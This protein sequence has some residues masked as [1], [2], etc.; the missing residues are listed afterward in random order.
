MIARVAGA[1]LRLAARLLFALS[2]GASLQAQA[3][4]CVAE[5]GGVID[6]FVTPTPPSQIQID[7]NCTVRNF[8]ASNPLTTNFSFLTQPGQTD[9]R[10]L[11]IF[12]NVVHTGNM[13]CDAVHEHK[14]WFTNSSIST[15]SPNC[16]NLL[17]PVEK[18]DKDSP[19][20]SA[21]IGV[22]FTYRL[23][24]PVL[25]D[26][27]TGNVIDF[28]GSPN[29]LHGII[30]TDDLNETGV[31]LTYLS[32]TAYWESSGAPVPHIFDNDAG[33]LTFDFTGQIVP[34]ETQFVIDITVVL[35][36]VPANAIGTSFVNT[37]KWQF[38]RLIDDV[39]YQ[40]LP[41]EWGISQ[42]MTIVAPDLTLTKSGPATMN[43]AP[44]GQ[45]VLD[46]HNVGAGDAWNVTIRDRLPDGPNGGMCDA[47][48][49]IVS[50]TIGGNPIAQ[51]SGYSLNYSGAPGCE[52]TLT[53]LD[54]AGPIGPDQH[55]LVTYRARLDADTDNGVTLTNVAGAV[56]WFNGNSTN[57]D[58]VGFNRPLTTG[59]VGTLDHQDAHTVTVALAG[60]LF[61][62]TVANLRSGDNP[63]AVAAP[64]DTLRYTLRVQTTNAS[65]DGFSIHD[66][67]DALNTPAAFAPGTLTL[68]GS[69]PPGAVNNSNAAGGAKGTGVIDISNLNLPANSQLIVQFDITV[70]ATATAGSIVANQAQI[71]TGSTPVML[72]D[73]PNVNG[74]ADPF[75]AGDEDPTRVTIVVPTLQLTKT[76]V[77][78]ST[79]SPSDVVRYRLQLTN[80]SNVPFSG[81]SLIDE[82][83]QLNSSA[84]FVPGTLALASALPG[85]ATNNSNASGGSRGTGLLDI[86]N[87]SIGAQGSPNDILTIEFTAQLVPVIDNGTVVLNQGRLMAG[88]TALL[89]SD[90]PAIAGTQDP[91]PIVI[92]S[93]PVFR[94][95]KVS[96]DM[97]G[98]ANVLLPGDTLR[99]TITVKNVGNANATDAVLRDQIPANTTYVAGSTRLNGTSVADVGGL[100][101][102]VSGLSI[103][104]PENPTPGAMRA[105]SSATTSN[106][107]TIMFDVTIDADT[108][109]GTIISNQAFISAPSNAVI[110]TPSDDPTTPIVSDPT[111]DIV[112]Y[113]PLIYAEK[114]A[115]L[116]VDGGTPGVID[117]NDV[118]RYTIT[119]YN[120]GTAAAT[121][122]ALRDQ[123]PANTTY[124]ADSTTL[125]GLPVARP[126]G[127][128][129]PLIAGLPISS[130]DLTPPVPAAGQGTLSV[131]ATATI[132]FDLRVNAGV[133]A[134]TLISNQATVYSDQLPQQL[135][136]GDGNPATGPEP[137]VV[138]VGSGQQLSITKQVAVVGGGAALAGSTL[139]YIVRVTNIATVPAYYIVVTDD[140][141][142]ATP[143]YLTYVD[144]S[145]TL[146]G[147]AAGISVAGSVITADYY[148]TY[149]PLQPGASAVLRFRATIIPNA[150]IGTRV[151]N[152]ADVTWNNPPQTARASVS[153]DVGGVVGVGILSGHVWHDA[154]FNQTL[155]TNERLFEDWRVDL[156]RNDRVVHTVRTDANGAY[157]ISGIAPNY[158][159]ADRYE[160]RFTAPNAS[161]STA[162]LGRAYSM[163]TNDLQRIADIIVQPGSNLPNMDLPLAPNGVVYNTIA[164]TPI[165]GATLTMRNGAGAALPSSCFYD[166]AQQ[167]Q[168]TLDYGYYRFDL[169]FADP[170]CPSG[171]DYFIDVT[172]PATGYIA[173]PSQIIPPASNALAAALSVPTCPGSADDAIAATAQ[174]CEVQP[175]EFAPQPAVRAR[176]IGTR[177]YLHMLFDDSLVPG[178][179][180]I[181]NNH[182]P[183]DPDM[184]GLLSLTKTTPLLNVTRGQL[185]PYTITYR[186]VT[187]VPLFDVRL[188]DRL[189]PGFSYV[190]GSARIDD[191]PAE[192]TL[193]GR[194]LLWSDL[195]VDGSAHHTLKLLLAVGAGVGEGEF[196]NR[197][198]SIHQ[199]TTRPLS[200]EATATV[201]VVPDATFD[202]T[203]VTGK[204]FD[205]VNRNGYQ[206]AGERG[207]SG[208]RVVSARGLTAITDGYGRFHITCAVTPREDRGSNFVLKLDDRTLPSGYRASTQPVRVERATRG[209]ALRFNF[210]ASIHRVVGLDLTDAVFEPGTTQM[211]DHWKPR[212][213]LLIEQLRKGPAVLRLSYLAD[214]ENEALVQRRLAA[215]KEEIMHRW[216]ALNCCYALT[217]EPEVF[218]RLGAPPQQTGMR[219]PHPTTEGR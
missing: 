30:V 122:V 205:D 55:L 204:V 203:D 169:S 145:A 89:L 91:T 8:P 94:V 64:G 202:C 182:I 104:A 112:G 76:V 190:K 135:T 171:S 18:I 153:I 213:D 99:Y 73:D 150:A 9:Q 196:V 134:G 48:P 61:E 12:D 211:R 116:E 74:A 82:I 187:E 36:D 208:V 45:F 137:T 33:R 107:A 146:N 98:D 200:N 163:F 188:I 95:Q 23:T 209:K 77:S 81:F 17:I 133:P 120:L 128:S 166:P 189:P 110:D 90:D 152:T 193:A 100:A 161:G 40:P 29:E 160:L 102:F 44:S 67:P 60:T 1:R 174:H 66:E 206:D 157:R 71:L 207:L 92:R 147:S 10:W 210:G 38:G 172:A 159:T 180:Q 7:G 136:D 72:S 138:V 175:S 151:T 53:L 132:Q 127:G 25:F 41:G 56:Q 216:E 46:V 83:D 75:V 22:P 109:E 24:I 118:L 184:Q 108:A 114:R 31:A 218:W 186:N 62:K 176:T 19:G 59:T 168:V 170:G 80:L 178:S 79:A 142:F 191:V 69:L 97:T 149:G 214:I 164:R 139:D 126:D 63:A 3:E 14:L 35:Q 140:L 117:P 212:L 156:Y 2:M 20:P 119:V 162:K 65:L 125:N 39:F 5:L 111:R 70:A 199:L 16:Q 52:L 101:P 105:D 28:A 86:R 87:L 155:E 201:R 34:A 50:V 183:I 58:R 143:G 11:V 141:N 21:A 4:D 106:V 88:G 51:G 84:R 121:G 13:S 124:V 154:N 215:I 192:P 113:L 78:G 115:A 179:S 130:S 49:Q 32:H 54:G 131:G 93:A 158:A 181:F 129:S 167:N 177:Y 148:S 68:V 85:A 103:Y 15:I 144:Q 26:P 6:G 217:V 165:T 198:Q 123:V 173:G 57:A 197:A 27:A 96:Q 195:S 43:F 194:E 185:V 37:A 42:P 219:E 47:T